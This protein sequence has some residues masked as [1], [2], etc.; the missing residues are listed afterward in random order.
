MAS[1]AC[2]VC[3]GELLLRRIPDLNVIEYRARCPGCQ[4]AGW[5]RDL[6]CG[7]CHGHR[8]F[9][10]TGEAWRC[11]RCGHVRGDQPQPRALPRYR[12]SEPGGLQPDGAETPPRRG[13][14]SRGEAVEMILEAIPRDRWV[15][16]AEIAAV[17]GVSP[18]EVGALISIHLL[19]AD[20]ERRPT[21]SP[22]SSSY[23]YRRLR[24]VDASR[25][26]PGSRRSPAADAAVAAV[27]TSVNLT[28]DQPGTQPPPRAQVRVRSIFSSSATSETESPRSRRA[29]VLLQ[30][31]SSFR[32]NL[33]PILCSVRKRVLFLLRR[34]EVEE[35]YVL[36]TP[37]WERPPDGHRENALIQLGQGDVHGVAD[38]WG[39]LDQDRSS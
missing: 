37:V 24:Y 4:W 19:G 13:P 27:G 3:G 16:A 9:E 26:T 8:L 38:P 32:A 34:H 33:N 18:H 29:N 5:L 2:P 28:G 30:D 25:R 31:P 15:S 20:V 39:K 21:R 22:W 17:A 7:G 10:W 1:P 23:L 12:P 14:W 36:I 11:L 35:G 6:W